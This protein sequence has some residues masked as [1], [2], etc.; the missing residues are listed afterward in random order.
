MDDRHRYWF[1][2]KTLFGQ[3]PALNWRGWA[4]YAV[5][6]AVWGI[7]DLTAVK[8]TFMAW[9]SIRPVAVVFESIRSEGVRSYVRTIYMQW[10]HH[11]Q[12]G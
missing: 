3:R 1:G 9:C 4:A 6:T 7:S 5:W 8:R 11:E 10:I 12:A 2:A